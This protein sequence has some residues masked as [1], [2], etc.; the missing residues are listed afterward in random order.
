MNPGGG[1]ARERLL[2]AAILLFAFALRVYGVGFGLPHLYHADEPVVVNHALAFGSLDFNPHFFKIPPLTSYVLFFVYGL[3]FLAGALAGK[4]S[5]VGDFE[6][7]FYADPGSFYW[8]ARLTF[9]VLLGT[10][11]VYALYRLGKRVAGPSAALL[12]ALFLAVCFLHARDSHYVY[13]DIPLGLALVTAFMGIFRIRKHPESVPAHVLAGAAIGLAAAVKY[14]GIFIAVPYLWFTLRIIPLRRLLLPWSAAGLAA[15]AVFFALNPY[16]ILDPSFFLSE[17]SSQARSNTG[18]AWT[19]HLVYSLAGAAGIP[20]VAAG[21]AGLARAVLSKNPERETLAVFIVAYYAVLCAWGQPYDRYVLALLP[22]LMLLAADMTVAV[23]A[24]LFKKGGLLLVFLVFFMVL[25]SLARI[26]LFDSIMGRTDTRTMARA[27]V[28]TN[29][30]DQDRLA[31]DWEF[32]APR[33]SFCKDQLDEKRRELLASGE[34]G[35]IKLRRLEAVASKPSVRAYRLF[36]MLR[37]TGAPRFLFGRPVIP[38]DFRALAENRIRYVIVSDPGSGDPAFYERLRTVAEPAAL[39]SPYR[40]GEDLRNVDPQPLTGGPFLLRDLLKR[41]RNGPVI[42]I[43][44][45]LE[46]P[47]P[48]PAVRDVDEIVNA[49][50][51]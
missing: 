34:K 39:F 40:A 47:G 6:G 4:F 28:E 42:R 25:P 44:R 26:L 45:L 20:L 19:H 14:N 3:Y 35:G 31:L 29:V 37:D 38:F 48:A 2:L 15:A 10:A 11:T 50:E 30:P 18:V 41:E 5:S 33:L 32:Y 22:F 8:L 1:A 49:R 7:L 16:A 51:S 46:A 13:A 27:W 17:L 21:L 9:G 12:G 36:F 23:Q 43:Y 24:L